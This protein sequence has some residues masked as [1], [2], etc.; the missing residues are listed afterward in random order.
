MKDCCKEIEAFWGEMAPCDHI[1][2]IYENDGDFLTG[3]GKFIADGLDKNESVVV[4]AT[5]GHLKAL[6]NYLVTFDLKTLRIKDQYIALDAEEI[7][8][9]FMVNDWPDE[10]LF[11]K[12]IT[13]ILKR[14]GKGGRNIRA[15]GEMVALLWAQGHN[16]ATIKLEHL[17][18]DLMKD[19]TFP[20][21]CA[22]PRSGFTDDAAESIKKICSAHS[23]V[24]P[25]AL[26]A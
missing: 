7:L 4:I 11:R 1:V 10:D 26:V 25:C 24:I 15:F 16:G 3:L 5:A 21:F 19:H 17:W 9:K 14:A 20:L 2:Q 12:S 8:S 13:A 22:Y 23:K 6:E 18:N